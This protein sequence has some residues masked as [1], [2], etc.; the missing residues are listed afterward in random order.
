V[1]PDLNGDEE[2]GQDEAICPVDFAS[3][4]LYIDDDIAQVFERLP[5]D[6]NLT[7]FM[8][9]CHSGT[10]SRFAVGVPATIPRAGTDMRKRYVVAT[11]ELVDAHARFRQKMGDI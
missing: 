9:C 1:V 10:N 4:A 3:G 2:D 7:C 11:P 8:D 5:D 6:V